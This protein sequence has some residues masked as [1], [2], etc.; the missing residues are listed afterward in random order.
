MTSDGMKFI[1]KWTCCKK[2]TIKALHHVNHVSFKGRP[3]KRQNSIY[4][5]SHLKLCILFQEFFYDIHFTECNGLTYVS[6][7]SSRSLHVTVPRDTVR[8]LCN[9]MISLSIFGFKSSSYA[10]FYLQQLRCGTKSTGHTVY[11]SNKIY[12][13]MLLPHCMPLLY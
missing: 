2:E 3:L 4:T 7:I 10:W 6:L 8:W 9:I 11:R 12:T 13:T 1:L 5:N